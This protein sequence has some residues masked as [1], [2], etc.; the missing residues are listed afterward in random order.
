[1]TSDPEENTASLS[2]PD[3]E[4]AAGDDARGRVPD[5]TGRTLGHYEIL[6]KLGAGGMGEVYR[7]RDTELHR[8]VAIK[9]LPERLAH[10]PDRLARLKREARTLAALNHP[11][12]ATLYGFE[13][14]GGTDCL[15]MELV[16]GDTLADLVR[17]GAVPL[18]QALAIAGQ[19]ADA[20]EAAHEKGITHRD[21]KPANIKVTPEGRVKVLDFGLAKST[22]VAEVVG[23]ASLT[24]ARTYDGQLVGTP[25]YMSPEQVRAKPPDHRADIWAFG[26]LLFELL[27]G[28]RPFGGDT[29]SDA[30][31]KI[32][33]RE[34]DWKALPSTTPVA[35]VHLIQR[36][37]AKDPEKR[38]PTISAARQVIAEAQRPG[39]RPSRRDVA[40][41][42]VGAAILVA[43][44]SGFWLMS[45]RKAVDLPAASGDGATPASRPATAKGEPRPSAAATTDTD[46]HRL[47]LQG[48]YYWNRRT[49]EDLRKSADFFQRAID[50]D[51]NYALAWAGKADA[52]LMLG[53]WS[54]VQPKDA[55]PRAKAAAERAIVLDE[56][57]AEPH[58][59]LGYLK[60]LYEWDW[61]GAEREFKR[62]IELQPAYGT[63]HH[64]Y[65]YYFVTVGDDAHAIKEIERAREIDP[66]SQVI[67]AEVS[68]VYMMARDYPRA[69]EEARKT[70]ELDPASSYLHLR[71]A[72]I[73]SLVGRTRDALAE[74]R[75]LQFDAS[76][77]TGQVAGAAAVYGACGDR[78]AALALIRDLEA[79]ATKRYSNPAVLAQAYAAIGDKARAFELLNRSIDERSLVVS[80]LRVPVYD[81]LR[82]DPRFKA[83]LDRLGLKM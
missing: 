25:A 83:L 65:A 38:L 53:A 29:V 20:L 42:A 43:V 66:L 30:L 33:E 37:L 31:A 12:I 82:A 36:C 10:D 52:Y 32:L 70:I 35:I 73:Y 13:S 49:D 64:W 6:S 78:V 51:P 21:I 45:R 28:E 55:Y 50:S 80:W 60:T 62:A 44:V 68:Y 63:A 14:S 5:L 22:G 39:W 61:P 71:L 11:N 8:D 74:L 17:R 15:A 56:S 54:V 76:H 46:A 1:M 18:G 19:V 41:A 59:T 9:V 57:L 72:E 79:Q 3:L 16:P 81:P 4:P 75:T 7:A 23:T 40:V 26:C 77:D 47:Y 27:S 67:N 2:R 34:P 48:R 69:L 58:A 24:V